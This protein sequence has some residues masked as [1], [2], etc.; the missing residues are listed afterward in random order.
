[1]E[2]TKKQIL[3]SY[4]KTQV[5][6]QLNEIEESQLGELVKSDLITIGLDKEPKII[7]KENVYL[8]TSISM[9]KE[10]IKLLG[11]TKTFSSLVHQSQNIQLI[12]K[13]K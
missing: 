10:F 8:N 5:R 9:D 2:K 7:R 1:M 12:F 4:I 11:K 13:N 3:E 6:K